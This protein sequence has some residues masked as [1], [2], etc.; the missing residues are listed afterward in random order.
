MSIVEKYVNLKKQNQDELKPP[1]DETS[2]EIMSKKEE[3]KNKH[4][5]RSL[6]NVTVAAE[7]QRV[8]NP[9]LPPTKPKAPTAAQLEKGSSSALDNTGNWGTAARQEK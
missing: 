9:N 1:K 7:A 4:F 6:G 8:F 2:E 5:V 3:K